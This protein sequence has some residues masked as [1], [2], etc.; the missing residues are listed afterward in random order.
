M[1]TS[2]SGFPHPRRFYL[3][4]LPKIGQFTT[5]DREILVE[6]YKGT[7]IVSISPRSCGTA[8]N[9]ATTP[10]CPWSMGVFH[11]KY[12]SGDGANFYSILL[13]DPQCQDGCQSTL[14]RNGIHSLPSMSTLTVRHCHI[15]R[16]RRPVDFGATFRMI[17]DRYRCHNCTNPRTGSS[18]SLFA[19]VNGI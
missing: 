11:N 10:S 6:A 12:G 1:C 16:P 4:K 8:R 3:A 9:A 15:S 2:L 17:G 19:P 5:L 13:S 18:P 7:I 14:V